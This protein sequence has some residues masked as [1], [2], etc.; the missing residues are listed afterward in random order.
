MKI[1]IIECFINNKAAK[2]NTTTITHVKIAKEIAKY[3]GCEYFITEPD[4]SYA[5]TQKWD[6]I[7]FTNCSQYGFFDGFKKI[8]ENNP[9]ARKIYL[10][11][12]YKTS[13][14]GILNKYQYEV[15]ANYEH[16]THKHYCVNTNALLAKP[17]LPVTKK[18]YDCIYWGGYR[19]DR[20]NYFNK[21]FKNKMYVS[22]SPKNKEKFKKAGCLCKFVDMVDWTKSLTNLFRYNLYIEDNW[23]HTNFHNLANRW[24]EAG[25]CNV[26]TFFDIDCKNTIKKSEIADLF[27]D[28]YYVSSYQELMEKIEICNK[29]YDK[30][31]KVQQEWHKRDLEVKEA[32]LK[33][34]KDIIYG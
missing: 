10:S 26:V 11:N 33:Q 6:V 13:P 12:D 2:E 31:L 20:E 19:E 23:I 22:T 3:L 18:K 28:F 1:A 24:Y 5:A 29:D 32:V 27:D 8:L 9:N 21:Y 16:S 7:I 17:M 14:P 15:I 25:M 4:I 34:I 30:H